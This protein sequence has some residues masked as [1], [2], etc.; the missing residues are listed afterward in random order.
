MINDDQAS[1][2]EITEADVIS[3]AADL[4]AL[5]LRAKVLELHGA[6]YERKQSEI[7]A[8]PHVRSGMDVSATLTNDDVACADDLSVIALY[9]ATLSV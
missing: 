3:S 2:L 6:V 1:K 9:A 8:H 5:L 4:H 7:T